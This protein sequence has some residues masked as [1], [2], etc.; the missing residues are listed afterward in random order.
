MNFDKILI[1]GCYFW[2]VVIKLNPSV[3]DSPICIGA[4][5]SLK[6]MVPREPGNRRCRPLVGYFKSVNYTE[7][8]SQLHSYIETHHGGLGNYVAGR[9]SNFVFLPLLTHFSFS[10]TTFKILHYGEKGF[11]RLK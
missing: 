9:A 4:F 1:V 8:M 10:G 3:P 11:L 2:S 5:W 7:G 6:D